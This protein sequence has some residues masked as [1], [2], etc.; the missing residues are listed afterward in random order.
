[1]SHS[2]LE[3]DDLRTEL[4]SPNFNHSNIASTS[5]ENMLVIEKGNTTKMEQKAQR[6]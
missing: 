1:M 2:K 5:T 3:T 6:L 4:F